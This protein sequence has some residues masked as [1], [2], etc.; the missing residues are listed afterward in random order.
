MVEVILT[1][2]VNPDS[3]IFFMYARDIRLFVA[4][5]WLQLSH[6]EPQRKEFLFR[7]GSR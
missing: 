6:D 4:T 2:V 5:A 7:V 3:E 1:R